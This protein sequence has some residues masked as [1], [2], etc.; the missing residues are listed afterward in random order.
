V[1]T[2]AVLRHRQRQTDAAGRLIATLED[3]DYVR[4]LVGAIYA[5]SVSG[6]S[7]AVRRTVDAVA[8]LGEQG[9][10]VTVTAVGAALAISKM[11]ASRQVGSAIR[12]G[13]IVNDETRKGHAAALRIGEP[14]PACYGLPAPEGLGFAAD[15]QGC[16][17]I[18]PLTVMDERSHS[19]E[20]AVPVPNVAEGV[21]P[22][23]S[24]TPVTALH[25]LEDR[26]DWREIVI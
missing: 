14:L 11:A 10:K 24:V 15:G 6:V 7:E 2:V 16:K 4:K 19:F 5:A 12:G 8:R 17:P 13:F 9:S 21:G 22:H 25:A 18:T 1:K 3:Y 26:A 20:P 23:L